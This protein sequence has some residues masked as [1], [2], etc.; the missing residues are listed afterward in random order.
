MYQ[1]QR[2]ESLDLV[3]N[4]ANALLGIKESLFCTTTICL[5][6]SCICNPMLSKPKHLLLSTA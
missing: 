1:T 2:V 6:S 4:A 5:Y 3:L